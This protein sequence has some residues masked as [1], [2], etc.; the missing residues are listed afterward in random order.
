MKIIIDHQKVNTRAWLANA[1]SIGGLV[2]LLASVLIPLF[3]PVFAEIAF[4]LLVFSGCLAIIGIYFANRWVR[5]PRPEESLDKAL[6]SL[7]DHYHIYHYASL[8]CDHV[9][10]TP[11]GVIALEVVNLSGSFSYRNGRWREAMTFGRAL[12]YIVE[13]RVGDPVVFSH[14]IVEEL[15]R[16]FEKELGGEARVPIKALTVFTHPA[17][18][19]DI[20]GTAIPV[21]RIEKLRKQMTMSSERLAPEVYEK[22]SSYLERVTLR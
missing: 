22:L 20:T 16:L 18:E 12:R 6:K 1:A 14:G 15:G 19:L 21:C 7:D 4:I 17:V 8:P 10:L 11:T 13:E 2:L 3:W 5:R 9:L